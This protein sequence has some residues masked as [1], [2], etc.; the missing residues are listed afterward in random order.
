M[1]LEREVTE[2]GVSVL[3]CFEEILSRFVLHGFVYQ[4]EVRTGNCGD[5]GDGNG[6]KSKERGVR[7]RVFYP[8]DGIGTIPFAATKKK[9]LPM[10]IAWTRRLHSTHTHVDP[11]VAWIC[12]IVHNA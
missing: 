2:I 11:R 8:S 6:Q 9:K 1:D 12:C 3:D 4:K 7:E 5:S 10:P